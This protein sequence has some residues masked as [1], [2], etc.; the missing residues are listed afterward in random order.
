MKRTKRVAIK[1]N[2]ILISSF[3][4][5]AILLKGLI[6]YISDFFN[7]DF[8]DLPG[9]AS[10]FPPLSKISLTGYASFV[11]DY[12][13]KKS[14]S[15]YVLGG[16]SM[17]YL[18][19]SKITD[20]RCKAIVAIEPYL[21]PD[22]LRMGSNVRKFI[23]QGIGGAEKTG[24]A[25][26]LLKHPALLIPLMKY[27]MHLTRSQAMSII[28]DMDGLTLWKL[29]RLLL[30]E[31]LKIEIPHKPHVLFFNP[32]DTLLNMKYVQARFRQEIKDLLEIPITLEHYPKELRRQYYEKHILREDMEKVAVWIN[33]IKIV[34]TV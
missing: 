15:S 8:I 11:K 27:F 34:D 16:I 30:S 6:D 18:L 2:L 14:Y 10:Y 22:F 7:V 3:G 9:F 20:P 19:A 12:L 29:L 25:E 5:N 23:K 4:S 31:E 33:K 21:G 13:Q 17:G 24:L 1:E 28:K 32:N 26:W